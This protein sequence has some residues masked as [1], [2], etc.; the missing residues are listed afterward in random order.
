MVA[1]IS[2]EWNQNRFEE[3]IDVGPSCNVE[4]SM[5]QMSFVSF[6]CLRS[7]RV[8]FSIICDSEGF[9]GCHV[10]SRG[11]PTRICFE[12]GQ[13]TMKNVR[14]GGTRNSRK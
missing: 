9:T 4:F 10:A 13:S 11:V 2:I 1:L 12:S 14:H 3:T 6:V 5:Q 8:R 7:I